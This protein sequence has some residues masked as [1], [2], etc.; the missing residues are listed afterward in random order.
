MQTTAPEKEQ[1]I[2]QTH[3]SLIHAVVQTVHDPSLRQHLDPVLKQSA[4]N[5]WQALVEAIRKILDGNRDMALLNGLDDEDRV[6]VDSILRGLQD[7]STLP[8]ASQAGDA[9]QAAPMMARLI[10]EARH[11]DANALSML[12]VMAEQMLQAGG[13]MANLSAVLKDMIDGERDA[14]KLCSRMGVQGESLV[15][16][17]LSELGKLD[18]H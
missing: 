1:Q 10:H 6:I 17:I 13:D 4:E 18:T 5:G 11:G 15:T 16:Q 3:A 12:G 9:T 2:L 7:P 14:D 8:E